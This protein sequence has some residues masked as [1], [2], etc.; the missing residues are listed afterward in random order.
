MNG[1]YWEYVH[2]FLKKW[3]TL[4]NSYQKYGERY[5]KHKAKW[6]RNFN[7]IGITV[8]FVIINWKKGENI[9]PNLTKKGQKVVI[10]IINWKEARL[11]THWSATV[12]TPL[13]KINKP[14]ND[15]RR[16]KANE[17]FIWTFRNLIFF[18]TWSFTVRTIFH[19]LW[20]FDD[21]EYFL[22]NFS[23]GVPASVLNT[24]QKASKLKICSRY[25]FFA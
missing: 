10:V 19:I 17:T 3:P 7:F 24:L 8:V 25:I 12:M 15:L 5:S 23:E 18:S 13:G 20:K 22:S 16:L 6:A 2:D 4:C 11:I 14:C 1:P 9:G 21:S